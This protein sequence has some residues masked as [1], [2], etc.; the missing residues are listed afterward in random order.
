MRMRHIMT[1][2]CVALMAVAAC[3]AEP[4]A[5]APALPPGGAMLLPEAALSTYS[6]LDVGRRY[7]TFATVSGQEERPFLRVATT[8]LPPQWWDVQL[9]WVGDAAIRK[10][11]TVLLSLRMRTASAQAA[12]GEALCNVSLQRT[13]SPWDSA[14][15]TDLQLSKEWQRIDLPFRAEEDFP[16]GSYQVAINL[17]FR[18]QAVDIADV[19]LLNYGSRL[20]PADLPRLR[21]SYPGREADAPWRA[22]AEKRIAQIRMGDLSVRVTDA[23]G[24]PVTG[25]TVQAKMIR[26]AFPFGA[27][28]SAVRL[29]PQENTSDSRKYR[30][31]V[32]SLFN[33][34]A[35]GSDMQWAEWEAARGRMSE[36][37]ARLW[38]CIEWMEKNR[39]DVRGHAMVWPEWTVGSVR[40]LPED[41]RPLVEAR[42]TEKLR[43]RV[44]GRIVE[45]GTEFRSHLADWDV[46]NEP[47]MHHVLQ[48]ALGPKALVDWFTWARNA[49][50]KA[51]L[52]V[53]DYCILSGGAVDEQRMERFAAI[54][55]S[56]KDAKADVDGIGE[57]GR[58]ASAVV[59]PEHLLSLLDRFAAFGWPIQIT[60]FGQNT[61]DAQLQ[62]DYLRDFYT[63]VFSHPSVNG[64]SLGA[65][66]EGEA[67]AGAALF[68]KDWNPKPNGKTFVEL[69]RKRW[70][71]DAQGASNDTGVFALR[72]YLGD[73]DVIVTTAEGR[74]ATAK[75]T[76]AKDGL[77]L[78]VKLP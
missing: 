14:L 9:R 49:D 61:D 29:D 32:A 52:Y 58:F 56:L 13:T 20:K 66:W 75:G 25:A 5:T 19:L 10:G 57:Q 24:K 37:K 3:A 28:V 30:D 59:A 54:L 71:T 4:P 44:R 39:I 60:A 67:T 27:V 77:A 36:H 35:F 38:R 21:V 48:D 15:N 78:T 17:G 64:I 6:V 68:R 51:K 53:N 18:L 23:A 26:H 70:W 65:F 33:R 69:T 16:V 76:L 42:D 50:P 22:E 41:L 74:K 1:L 47:T 11:D 31:T 55:K 45:M 8:T 46:V 12:T 63:A 2:L 7:A 34:A 43:Q 40:A 62:A 72:G 73:Y